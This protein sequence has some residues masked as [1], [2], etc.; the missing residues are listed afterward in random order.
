MAMSEAVRPCILP[1]QFGLRSLF[2]MMASVA[3]AI[4]L[5]MFLFVLPRGHIWLHDMDQVTVGMTEQDVFKIH[6]EPL[7]KSTTNH[8]TFW[9]YKVADASGHRRHFVVMFV[10]HKVKMDYMG[11]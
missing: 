2:L 4:W 6:G 8:G 1:M 11:W 10:D 7:Y 9:T 5:F 3:L